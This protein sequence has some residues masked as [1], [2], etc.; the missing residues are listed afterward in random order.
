MSDCQKTI[1]HELHNPEK[2]CSEEDLLDVFPTLDFEKKFYDN[3]VK[4]VS[5]FFYYVF[6]GLLSF[7]LLFAH[8]GI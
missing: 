3:A 1:I 4:R 7:F 5:K 8:G 6:R 2:L